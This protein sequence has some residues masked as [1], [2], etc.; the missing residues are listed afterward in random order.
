MP[1]ITGDAVSINSLRSLLSHGPIADHTTSLTLPSHGRLLLYLSGHGGNGFLKFRNTEE[2]RTKEFADM[3]AEAKR[4]LGFTELIVVLDT[5]EAESLF[6]E[7]YTEGVT[8]IG[9]SLIGEKAQSTL[10][11]VEYGV[12]LSD[13]F[14]LGMCEALEKIGKGASLLDLIN[15]LRMKDL[16]SNVCIRQVKPARRP[17]EMILDDFFGF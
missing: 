2:L 8:M 10:F 3:I 6:Q 5:C 16:G 4:I 9:S 7:V 12:P 14:T 15:L 1:N 11:D 13:L 17:S